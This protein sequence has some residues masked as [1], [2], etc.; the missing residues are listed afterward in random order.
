MRVVHGI[1]RVHNFRSE[2]S[3]RLRRVA[4]MLHEIDVGCW[5]SELING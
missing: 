5:A 2:Q 4:S 3:L 1:V